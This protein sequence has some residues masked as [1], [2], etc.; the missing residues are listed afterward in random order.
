MNEQYDAFVGVVNFNHKTR[1]FIQI[2]KKPYAKI[3]TQKK[4]RFLLSL[5]CFN[6]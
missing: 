4:S 1:I 2:G 6:I 5:K 3:N